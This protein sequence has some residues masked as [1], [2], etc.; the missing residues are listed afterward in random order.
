MRRLLTLLAI[1]LLAVGVQAQGCSDAGVCT[2]GPIGDIVTG[3][4]STATAQEPPHSVRSTFSYAIGER[5]V[6]ILQVVAQLDLQ[7]TDRISMQAKMPWIRASGDLGTNSGIGDPVITGS[8]RIHA[9]RHSRLDATLGIKLPVNDANAEFDG[10]PLPMP[11]Q[12]SLGTTDLL[13]GLSYRSGRW[14]AALAYQHVLL[15]GNNNEFRHAVWMD[16]M[17]AVGYFE[18]WELRRANDAVARIQYKFPIGR[19]ALQPGILAIQ[20]LGKDE[21]LETPVDPAGMLRIPEP[22]KVDGS[23]G[24]TL[25]LTLDAQYKLSDHWVLLFAYGSPVVVRDVRPDGLTR[26]LVMNVGLVRRFGR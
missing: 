16:D 11:Y 21:R 17:H 1:G 20:H 8:Y 4:D 6:V 26:S 10:K 2:A 23:E 22:T 24:L 12:T 19:L 13:S 9:T 15:Q 5:G 14:Q 18:S 7:L 25:N 3:G